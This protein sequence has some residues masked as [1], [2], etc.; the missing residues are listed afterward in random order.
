MTN[1]TFPFGDF[2]SSDIILYSACLMCH[3]ALF[4]LLLC[5]KT[6]CDNHYYM[7]KAEQLRLQSE[8]K[9]M[10]SGGDAIQKSK[11]IV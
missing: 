6:K 2:I 8:K 1:M 11:Y 5:F 10:Y 7:S 3:W 9:E 4:L